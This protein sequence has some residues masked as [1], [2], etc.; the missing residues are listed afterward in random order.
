VVASPK[1]VA[2]MVALR[3]GSRARIVSAN[4]SET[5]GYPCWVMS[6]T[7]E[8]RMAG[9]AGGSKTS[10]RVGLP[11]LGDEG[12]LGVCCGKWCVLLERL[13]DLSDI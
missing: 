4:V 12:M 2:R 1:A 10:T 11:G 7:R 9:G 6:L 13:Y 3:V 5:G 8:K